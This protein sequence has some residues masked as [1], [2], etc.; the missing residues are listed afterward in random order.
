M[1]TPEQMAKKYVTQNVQIE[2]SDCGKE[3]WD[4]DTRAFLA[5]FHARD[6]Y[7]GRL[8]A[9]VSVAKEVCSHP[10]FDCANESFGTLLDELA[11][12]LDALKEGEK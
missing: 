4:I 10:E 9:V 5:G 7:V 8:E 12:A 3:F 1:K 11:K 6:E 2:C